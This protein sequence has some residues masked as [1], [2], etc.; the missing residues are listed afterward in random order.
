MASERPQ[1]DSLRRL[2]LEQ[3]LT[4][5]KRKWL[6]LAIAWTV[7]A[8]LWVGV[9][10]VPQSFE[11]DAR[12]FVDVNGLLTPLLKGLIVDTTPAE[13]EGYLRQTLLSRPNLDQVIVLANLGPPN[14]PYARHEEL[15]TR[16][17]NDIKVKADE[18]NLV[19]ISYTDRNPVTAKNVVDALLT[20]FAEKAASSTRVEMDK[21][22]SFL[23][24]QIAQ[25]ESELR[26]AEGRRA[27]FR[28]KY[29]N[30]FTDA[31]VAK[32]DMLQQQLAQ[33]RQQ[34]EDGLLTRNAI[35]AQMAQVP[36]LLAVTSAP[37]ISNSGQIVVASPETRLAQAKRNLADLELMYTD[38]HPDV[39]T[40][41]RSVAELQADVNAERRG[42]Q[43]NEGKTQISNPA[44]EQ[45][46][47]KFVDAEAVLPT[48]KERLDKATADYDRA[49]SLSGDVPDI[50]AKSQ[51]LDRDYEV[52]KAN[53]D[54]LVKRREATNL[55]QA[56]DDRADRTQF[57]IVDP[58]QVPVF[59]SFP[60]RVLL[61]S[62]ATLAG[63]GA[64]LAAPI[65]LAQI[66]PTFTSPARLRE[67]GLPVAG[68]VTV[69]RA[70]AR[71]G[72]TA[73]VAGAVFATAAASLLLVY[74]GL[75]FAV[76]GLYRGLW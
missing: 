27:A 1:S 58:P 60:D 9:L 66:H 24:E 17:A 43:S 62:M 44:Y 63:I 56:A 73:G 42:T 23:N 15:V 34:Y 71:R 26:A 8:A 29:A 3:A 28:K 11:S 19:S 70:A 6:V 12:A 39:V 50:E 37:A 59:P 14:M 20:I 52:L 72:M 2:L 10:F 40:A 16:L 33:A 21:A 31:G 54:E 75:I 48:L 7:C 47:L 53:Y 5:W 4:V 55:S 57:R 38:K 13:S 65:L 67:L 18:N 61:F 74:G 25:Y 41:K 68:A 64:G 51:D 49:K 45:L 22:R 32:P 76:T 35:G 36:Q 69:V 30:Y 46:R